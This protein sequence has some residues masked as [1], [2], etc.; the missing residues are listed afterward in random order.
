MPLPGH[1]VSTSTTDPTVKQGAPMARATARISRWRAFRPPDSAGAIYGTI[2]TMAVIAGAARGSSH[3]RVLALAVGT[4]AVFWLAHV[5]AHAL[6]HHLRGARRLDWPAI[7]A[8]M[9]EERTMLE[10]PAVMFLLLALGGIHLLDTHLAV[11]LALWVGVAQL[12]AWGV[13]YA[14]G[15]RWGWS[16]SVTAGVVN[17]AFGLVI[18]VL[19]VLIH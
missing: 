15:Q 2:A 4:V 1:P 6:A 8:A 14:R 13:A 17:G 10:A 18:V 19:E 5:Y 9:A 16:T 12:V 3:G 7:T 11:R